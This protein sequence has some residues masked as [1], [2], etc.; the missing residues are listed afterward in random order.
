MPITYTCDECGQSA[1]SLS[2][3][4]LVGIQL[5]QENPQAPVPP[6]GRT[7]AQQLPDLCFHAEACRNAWLAKAGVALPAL[8][9]PPTS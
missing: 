3:W 6:G 4:L 9:P 7:L 5:L 8:P 1:T 2:G